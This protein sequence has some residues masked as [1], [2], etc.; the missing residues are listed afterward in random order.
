ML[1]TGTASLVIA[2]ADLK[3]YV[4]LQW[5]PHM[6]RYHQV[7][8]SL[9]LRPR[10]MLTIVSGDVVLASFGPSFCV[11]EFCRTLDGALDV[12]SFGPTR[13]AVSEIPVTLP[14]SS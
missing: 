13:R 9:T 12:L 3:P 4:H 10:N 7:S 8:P 6:S 2:L 11:Y 14:F 5:N 1:L